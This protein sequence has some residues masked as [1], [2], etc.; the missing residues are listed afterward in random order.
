MIYFGLTAYFIIGWIL[1]SWLIFV[2][3]KKDPNSFNG[4]EWTVFIVTLL[5]WPCVFVIEL[6]RYT[7]SIFLRLQNF[8]V[9]ILQTPQ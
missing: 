5:I 3:L 8:L 4:V 2:K 6:L 1:I 7:G 9:R